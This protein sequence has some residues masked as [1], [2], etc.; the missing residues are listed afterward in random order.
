MPEYFHDEFNRLKMN[1]KKRMVELNRFL[2]YVKL[3]LQD[4]QPK[5]IESFYNGPPNK[6]STRFHPP[7]LELRIINSARS[8]VPSEYLVDSEHERDSITTIEE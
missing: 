3:A 1:V 4:Q 6:L 5:Y 7:S 2:R 8:D